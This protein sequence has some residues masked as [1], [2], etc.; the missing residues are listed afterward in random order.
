M[1][2]VVRG[3]GRWECST[4]SRPILKLSLREVGFET[5]G[6]PNPTTDGFG[7]AQVSSGDLTSILLESSTSPVDV[8]P[9]SMFINISFHLGL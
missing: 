4:W 7:W 3:G 9:G 5:Q 1:H 6:E 2:R 8:D